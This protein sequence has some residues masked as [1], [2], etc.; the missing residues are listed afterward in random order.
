[1]LIIHLVIQFSTSL[2]F[3]LK[4]VE[5]NWNISSL[6]PSCRSYYHVPSFLVLNT[7]KSVIE[8]HTAIRSESN[9][10]Q[11]HKIIVLLT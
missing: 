8:I 6:L 4:N 9:G 5:D 10:F 7:L 11:K 2:L 1:M 3:K